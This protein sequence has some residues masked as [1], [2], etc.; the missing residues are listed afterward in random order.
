MKNRC[1]TDDCKNSGDH[2]LIITVNGK[3]IITQLCTE[4]KQVWENPN[5]SISLEV[6]NTDQIPVVIEK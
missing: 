1:G 5:S 3:K 4:C 6:L 2:A